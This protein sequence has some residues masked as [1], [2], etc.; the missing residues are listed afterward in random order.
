MT[1]LLGDYPVVLLLVLFRVAALF[2][3]VP[4]F[5]IS[6]GSG[7]LLAAASLPVTLMIASILPPNWYAAAATLTTPGDIAWALLGEVLL[8]AAMGTI[9]SV[10]V[11]AFDLAGRIAGQGMS[12]SMAQEMDPVTGESTGAISQI[13]RMLF[14]VTSLALNAHLV[15]IRMIAR[16]FEQIPVPWTGWMHVGRDL[17]LLTRTTFETGTLIAMPVMVVALLVTIA[18]AL[19][20]RMAEQ[21]NVLFLSLPFRLLAGF[22]I[23]MTTVL[24]NGSVLRRVASDM[25]M[26]LSRFLAA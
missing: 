6:R 9:C 16:S 2:F 11:A 5:G 15:M 24:M 7:W 1:I 14:L 3:M 20:A 23:L 17:A 10:F 21:F 18:M 12:L 19:M 4:L 26:V 25:L 13:W 8:G 22:M